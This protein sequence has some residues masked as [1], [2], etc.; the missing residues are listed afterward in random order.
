FHQ[1]ITGQTGTDDNDGSKMFGHE[2]VRS[3]FDHFK[4]VFTD[5]AVRANKISRY[6]FPTGSR[7]NAFFR[8]AQFFVINPATYYALPLFHGHKPLL[9]RYQKGAEATQPAG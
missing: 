4:V 7:G 8:G 1:V 2:Y 3:D 5:A 6:I 9:H